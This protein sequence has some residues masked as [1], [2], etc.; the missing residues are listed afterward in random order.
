MDTMSLLEQWRDLLENQTDET[1][2]Q[3][4][5]DYSTAETEIYTD[6]LTNHTDGIFAGVVSEAA[7]KYATTSV[8]F[9]GFLDG[10]STSLKKEIDLESVA[11]D[12]SFHLEIDFEKLYFN[13]HDAGVDYLYNIPA[14][15]NILTEERRAEIQKEYKKSKT[16]VKEK[17]PGRNDP[18][19]CGSG[20]K[21][22]KC[23]GKNK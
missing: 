4:W 20:L 16:I 1:I 12:T 5:T 9:T 15:E 6:I 17:L 7:E 19:P 10:I 3:F 18:C 21:Y 13:M 2:K 22:K 8:I 23:C 11:E 14:W